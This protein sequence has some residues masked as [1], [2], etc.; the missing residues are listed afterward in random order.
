[1]MAVNKV[2]TK[3]VGR[4]RKDDP[5]KTVVSVALSTANARLLDLWMTANGIKSRSK[6]VREL[7]LLGIVSANGAAKGAKRGKK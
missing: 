5:I 6:A 2:V 4:P 3:S 1:M 7:M